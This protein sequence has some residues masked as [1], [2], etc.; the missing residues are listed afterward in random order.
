M[1]QQTDIDNSGL[2]LAGRRAN[3][4][5]RA[6]VCHGNTRSFSSIS[7]DITLRELPAVRTHFGLSSPA[8]IEKNGHGIRAIGMLGLLTEMVAP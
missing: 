7:A 8:F 2:V 5:R 4:G 3:E 1:F 6:V